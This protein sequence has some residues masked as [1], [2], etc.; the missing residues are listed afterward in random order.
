M[1]FVKGQMVLLEE[2]EKEVC[3]REQTSFLLGY[4]DQTYI[5]MTQ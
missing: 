2:Q 1:V 3:S 4:E 5:R